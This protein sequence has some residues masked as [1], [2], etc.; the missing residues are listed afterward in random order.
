LLSVARPLEDVA[1]EKDLGIIINSVSTLSTK[2]Q[3]NV[4]RPMPKQARCLVL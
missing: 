4:L 1:E 2:Y 3:T